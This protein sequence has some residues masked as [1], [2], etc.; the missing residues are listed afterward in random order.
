MK[1]RLG[2][3]SPPRCAA[4]S[5]PHT[6]LPA[7]N[8]S[9]VEPPGSEAVYPWPQEAVG[10]TAEGGAGCLGLQVGLP[11]GSSASVESR[12]Q[13]WWARS[14]QAPA[15]GSPR[16]WSRFLLARQSGALPP[17]SGEAR[18]GSPPPHPGK[19]P[20]MNGLD[21]TPHYSDHIQRRQNPSPLPA[22]AALPEWGPAV[23]VSLFPAPTI[24]CQ[25]QPCCAGGARPESPPRLLPSMTSCGRDVLPGGWRG[26]SKR[27]LLLV[28]RRAPPCPAQA[29]L[30][31]PLP[32]AGTGWRL[33]AETQPRRRDSSGCLPCALG[34]G[35]ADRKIA[36]PPTEKPR[37]GAAPS[38]SANL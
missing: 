32:E 15:E 12:R 13:P 16:G 30:P 10:R 1:N 22:A 8:G 24:S 25:Q 26:P 27:A 28:R 17:G 6:A 33:Q 35:S 34:G 20:F 7:L 36:G 29:R 3:C 9:V 4:R 11:G 23:P 21:M 19:A 38:F 2:G 5:W 18:L 31:Q 37:A 14:R